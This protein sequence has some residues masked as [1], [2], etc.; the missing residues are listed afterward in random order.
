M[1]ASLRAGTG[2]RLLLPLLALVLKI[3]VPP[4][5]MPGTSLA[6]PIV[7]CSGQDAMAAM[8]GMAMG[9]DGHR[10]HHGASDQDTDHPCAF[11]GLGAAAL[12]T[13]PHQPI[14]VPVRAEAQIAATILTA[15]APG[16]G[17]AAPPPPSHA[18]PPA[19]A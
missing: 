11:A 19:F 1:L 6:E 13:P 14:V 8:P 2:W 4:G 5:Y 9:D 17:M 7:L 3:L 16:R 10:Q 12:A 15:V 18:P